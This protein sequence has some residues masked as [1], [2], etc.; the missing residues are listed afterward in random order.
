MKGHVLEIDRARGLA[1]ATASDRAHHDC[2]RRREQLADPL[3]GAGRALQVADHLADRTQGAG[4]DHRIEHEGGE[5]PGTD[6]PGHHVGAAD[7]QHD[8]DRPEHQQ[9][10]DA[11]QDRPPADAQ[12]RGGEGLLGAL[13][14]ARAVV[15]LVRKGL[16]GADAVERFAGLGADLGHLVLADARQP[17]HLAPEQHDRRH[18]QRHHRQHQQG[19]LRAGDEQHDHAAQDQQRVAQCDRYRRADHDLQQRGVG[20]EARHHLAGAGD[21]EEAGAEADDVIEHRLADIGDHALPDP[22]HQIEAREGPERQQHRD[23]EQDQHRAVE[24]RAVAG[25][26]K[27]LVDQQPQPGAERQRRA[28]RDH[29]REGC[30]A[31]EPP[32]RRREPREMEQQPVVARDLPIAGRPLSGGAWRHQ[33]SS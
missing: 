4:Q 17:P 33:S 25:R 11:G 8:A 31:D 7:P 32:V 18:H 9:D 21:L 16:H 13:G 15:R 24:Q 1:A 5:L 3:H 12:Q 30:P 14:E 29:Q 23:A 26:A 22:G 10:D 20:G 19:Q 27:A 2:G 6:P 28:C